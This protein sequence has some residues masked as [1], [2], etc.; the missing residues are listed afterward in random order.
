MCRWVANP[1]PSNQPSVTNQFLTRFSVAEKDT[2][3]RLP[4]PGPGSGRLWPAPVTSN[5][6]LQ[7]TGLHQR[8]R[9]SGGSIPSPHR[10][11]KADT[12]SRWAPSYAWASVTP[13]PLFM[14]LGCA[15]AVV[16]GPPTPAHHHRKLRADACSTHAR[17]RTPELLA[18]SLWW[19]VRHASGE[20]VCPRCWTGALPHMTRRPHMAAQRRLAAYRSS[21]Q[22]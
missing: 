18:H 16:L 5:G 4:G 14:L 17:W 15:L 1:T 20:C 6:R 3:D 22:P 12:R 8:A 7:T 10:R 11:L 9:V 2:W 19:H 13:S 21:S